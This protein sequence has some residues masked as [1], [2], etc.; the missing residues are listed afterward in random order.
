MLVKPQSIHV[1]GTQQYTAAE[2]GQAAGVKTGQ[3]YTADF[4]SQTAQKLMATG[5]FEKVGFKFDGQDLI[6]LIS[7][8]PDLYAVVIDNLPLPP[9]KDI[10]S[11]LRAQVPLYRGKVPSEGAVLDEVRQ[12]LQ[13]MLAQQGVQATVVP[14]PA[15]D[16]PGKKAT[17]MKFRIDS[18]TVGIGAITVQG[19]SLEIQARIPAPSLLALGEYKADRSPAEIQHFY[20]FGLAS[21][22]YAS[23]AVRVRSIGDPQVAPGSISVPFTVDVTPGK[24]YKLG[25]VRIAPDIPVTMQELQS[26]MRPRTAFAPENGYVRAVVAAITFRL[27]SKGYLDCKVDAHPQLDDPSGIVNYTI[28]AVTGPVYHFAF[29][30]FDNVSDSLKALLMHNWQMMPGDPFNEN[31]ASSF[32]LNAQNSDPVLMRALSGVKATFDVKTD[33]ESHDVNLIIRLSR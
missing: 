18:P 24:L 3:T 28:D 23:A 31:Y 30:K 21:L 33:P 20:E 25:E 5:M 11:E 1:E 13:S 6:Y 17:A 15:G 4:L 27:K 9:D 26:M 29:V 19:L 7:D 32:M 12:A 14:V 16:N 2:I 10:D 22:G 8:S